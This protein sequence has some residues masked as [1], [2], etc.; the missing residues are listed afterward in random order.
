MTVV[1]GGAVPRPDLASTR[2]WLSLAEG[3]SLMS[4][5]APDTQDRAILLQQIQG[6][7]LSPENDERDIVRY[8]GLDREHET[9]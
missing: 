6:K 7:L 8:G 4:P 5:P 2:Y 9:R 1:P 3:T